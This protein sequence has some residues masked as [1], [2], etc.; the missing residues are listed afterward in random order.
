MPDPAETA[1]LSL[2]PTSLDCLKKTRSGVLNVL[3]AVG[4]VVA[5]SGALLRRRANDVAVPVPVLWNQVLFLWLILIF[6]ASTVARRVLGRRARLRDPN[7][8]ERRFFWG[9]VTPAAIGALAAPLGL[10]YGWLVSPRIEAI[11]PFWLAALLLGILAYPRGRELEDLGAPM[12]LHG[13][14]AP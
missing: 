9:H 4:A 11:L 13:K 14:L 6:V 7:L 3:L 10:L 2:D 5:L 12:G 8:R 1:E